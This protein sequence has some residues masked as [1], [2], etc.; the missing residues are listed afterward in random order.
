MHHLLSFSLLVRSAI[1]CCLV[2]LKTPEHTSYHICSFPWWTALSMPQ[3]HVTELCCIC[4]LCLCHGGCHR[5]HCYI[6]NLWP[7]G[8]LEVQVGK[9]TK[10]FGITRAHLEEDAGQKFVYDAVCTH[11]IS[12]VQSRNLFSSSFPL[13]T[14]LT[15]MILKT[16]I[17]CHAL[18]EETEQQGSTNV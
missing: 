11:K 12:P 16:C 1:E 17:Q 2:W 6:C 7:A 8:E 4:V 18:H 10:T 9:E 13:S 5:C 3:L 14:L 15:V